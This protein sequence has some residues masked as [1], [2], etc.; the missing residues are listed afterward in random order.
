MTGAQEQTILGW[1]LMM[2]GVISKQW[3]ETQASYWKTYKSRKSSKRWT[4]ALIQKLLQIAWDM[5]QHQNHAFHQSEL[6]KSTILESNANT[7][8]RAIYDLGSG[9]V[10]IA[11]RILWKRTKKELIAL[12]LA[13]K[14]QWIE[15][16]IIAQHKQVQQLAG[17]TK[18]NG[19]T[20]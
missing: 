13:Y 19:D 1:E 3:R 11:A 17:P 9:S 6:N 15:P 4:T 2:E 18:V 5:W 10:P 12:P 7:H 20:C 14:Q 8:L 16:A